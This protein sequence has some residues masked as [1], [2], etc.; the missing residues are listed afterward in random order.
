MW[1]LALISRN[2]VLS[3]FL[4]ESLSKYHSFSCQTNYRRLPFRPKIYILPVMPRETMETHIAKAVEDALSNLNLITIDHM[5]SLIV[6]LKSELRNVLSEEVQKAT[7]SL[8]ERVD[9]LE[10]K[11]AVYETHLKNLETRLDDAEQYSRR[12]CQRL[13]GLPY[14]S[15]GDETAKQCLEKVSKIIEKELE[16]NILANCIDRVHRIG[17]RTT[18]D[19]VI[20]QA[21]IIKLSSW[22]HC[23]SIFRARKNLTDSKVILL[24]L[25]SRRPALLS[26]I[27]KII[28]DHSDIRYAFADIHCRLGLRLQVENFIS[29]IAKESY[30]LFF[31]CLRFFCT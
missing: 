25:T 22:D 10:G 2:T 17:R 30:R 11:L 24:G 28:K 12:S 27:K 1:K 18:N 15:D 21:V 8:A 13:Y 5:D 3:S 14:P 20:H 6:G 31:K 23:V 19:G 16:L 9:T 29:S 26:D 7:E 4:H